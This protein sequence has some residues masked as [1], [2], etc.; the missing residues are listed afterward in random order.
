MSDIVYPILVEV[1]CSRGFNKLKQRSEVFQYVH[2][3]V[4]ERQEIPIGTIFTIP[5]KYV[6]EVQL[7]TNID[8]FTPRS[9]LQFNFYELHDAAPEEETVNHGGEE[10][11]IAQHWLLPSRELHGLW[12]SLIYDAEIKD[13]MLSFAETSMLFSRKGVSTNL[14]TCNRLAL[15][16]GPPGTG[17]TSL[18]KA[19][20]QKLSIRLNEHY[21]HSHL[22][23]I[24]SHSLFS[25]WFSESGRLVKKVFGEITD[26]LQD[27]KCLVCVLVD[28]IESIVYAREKI[29]SNEPSDSIRVVNAVLTQLDRIRRYSNVFI[30]ATSNLTESIDAAFL[31]RA[32]FVQY[33]GYPKAQGIYEIYRMALHDLIEVGIIK[34]EETS[35]SSQT[36]SKSW[37]GE[38][39]P[40]H[41]EAIKI[42]R[43]PCI[44]LEMLLQVVELSTGLSGRT[45]RKIP[46]LAHAIFV[47]KE[48]DSLLNFLSA[49][50]QAIRKV[51][52]DNELL[53]KDM[54]TLTEKVNGLHLDE[55]VL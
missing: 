24:N 16:H 20:A 26:L 19:I 21:T 17:K 37:L 38:N 5:V 27:P 6:V 40:P 12:E 44:V 52:S 36:L 34:R 41:A 54:K 32:D 11:D 51:R 10:V 7:C 53:G 14:V 4:D 8:Q 48:S 43:P 50:R 42:D 28:E 25:R 49:M 1:A 13:G 31:D 30:L 55:N 45:L 18:C 23:E 22:V 15:F 2:A 35:I 3:F 33:I 39:I 46:F 9:G 47:K 29:S